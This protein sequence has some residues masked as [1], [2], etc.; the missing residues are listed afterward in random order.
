MSLCE[1]VKK[2]PVIPHHLFRHCHLPLNFFI[3]RR[4]LKTHRRFC[5]KKRIAFADAELLKHLL[6]QNDPGGISN[7]GNF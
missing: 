5:E 2:V 6:R 7:A 1:L 3:Q 4:H